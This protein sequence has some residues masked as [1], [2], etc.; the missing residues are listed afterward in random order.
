MV[1]YAPGGGRVLAWSRSHVVG[2]LRAGLKAW[3]Q[4]RLRPVLVGA[5]AVLAHRPRRGVVVALR[6]L[7][8]LLG[9][10]GVW[11]LL[12]RWDARHSGVGSH[13]VA[14][15]VGRGRQRLRIAACQHKTMLDILPWMY[16]GPQ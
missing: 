16:T 11:D 10:G 12:V 1:R 15:H 4:A 13:L 3:L 2:G 8:R 7:L 9:L 14:V 5:R 6:I